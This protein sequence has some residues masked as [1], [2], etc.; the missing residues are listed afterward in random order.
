[1]T[2]ARY[3]TFT[4][5][6]MMPPVTNTVFKKVIFVLHG[7]ESEQTYVVC[8]LASWFGQPTTESFP[9]RRTTIFSG[10]SGTV[11][12]FCRGLGKN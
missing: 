2:P 6:R 10:V 8:L 9:V 11:G 5:W 12:E 7:L 4:P 3:L 1:L